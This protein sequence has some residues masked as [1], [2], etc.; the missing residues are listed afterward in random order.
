MTDASSTKSYRGNC[1][2]GAFVYTIVV[3]EIKGIASCNCSFC[4]KKGVLWT[5]IPHPEDQFTIVKGKEG[6]LA[7]YQFG[8]RNL[9]HKVC[10]FKCP[11]HLGRYWE[12]ADDGWS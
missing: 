1:H 11:L 4:S 3:P 6:D 8:S 2:C 7:V 5:S 10:F 12:Y 9:S